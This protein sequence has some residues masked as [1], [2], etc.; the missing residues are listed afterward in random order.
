MKR[1]YDQLIER[2]FH[3][4]EEMLLLMGP[5]QVG[6]TTSSLQASTGYH[7]HYLNWDDLDQ[8]KVIQAGPKAVL[9][10]LRLPMV[11]DQPDLLIFD[12]IH[13]WSMWKDFLKGFYDVHR[14]RV[15][16]LVTGSA[17]LDVLHQAGDSMMGRYFRYRFHPLSHAVGSF[18]VRGTTAIGWISISFSQGVQ[19]NT[20]ALEKITGRAAIS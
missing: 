17:R 20:G 4:N 13:K 10:G 12:E 3:E 16:F 6:K 5:R 7:P 19:T 8:R 15:R 2:H 1:F 11:V 18:V 14:S 9:D